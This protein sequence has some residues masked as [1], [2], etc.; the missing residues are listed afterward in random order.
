[1]YI[2]TCFNS[3][4]RFMWIHSKK[5]K[6]ISVLF[7]NCLFLMN[8]TAKKKKNLSLKRYSSMIK[9][10]NCLLQY[11][12][13]ML[14]CHSLKSL[15]FILKQIG[16]RL[17]FCSISDL[18]FLWILLKISFRVF[19]FSLYVTLHKQE[20]T[21]FRQHWTFVFFDSH[22][23]SKFIKNIKFTKF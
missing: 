12:S 9:K 21:D 11:S 19:H 13:Y 3:I 2:Y 10:I 16:V 17:S 5:D 18:W 23:I 14:Q 4:K 22:I 1:M 7:H 15:H 8:L 20:C 6:T